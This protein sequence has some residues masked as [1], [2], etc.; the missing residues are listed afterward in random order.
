[1]TRRVEAQ[2]IIDEYRAAYF[3][4]NGR[5]LEKTITYESGWFVFR[6]PSGFLTER[7][8]A[9]HVQAMKERLNARWPS[10]EPRAMIA[11]QE[12]KP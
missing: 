11:A 6:S 1:M 5:R 7:R 9:A 12:Q 10:H 2:V 3:Q 4:A 8:R